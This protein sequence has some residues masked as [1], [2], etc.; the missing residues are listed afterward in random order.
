MNSEMCIRDRLNYADITIIGEVGDGCLAIDAVRRL[1]PDVVLMD[2]HMPLM[3]GLAAA[4]LILADPEPPGIVLLSGDVN[5][6]LCTAAQRLGI[7]AVLEK[8]VAPQVIYEALL[9]AQTGRPM[10]RAYAA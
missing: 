7:R 5:P 10:P 3:D 4:R 9:L 2:Y 8:G 1:R 6:A